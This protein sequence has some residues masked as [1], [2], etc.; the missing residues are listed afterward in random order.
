MDKVPGATGE[1]R[2][3]QFGGGA[4]NLTYE[5]DF[6]EAVY[7]LRRPPLGPV[8]PRSHDMGREH[9]V[10]SR[11]HE[12]FPP[13]PRS[14]HFCSDESIIGAPF[15][16]MERRYGVV[17]RRQ[18]PASYA[19]MPD[20]PEQL[21][22]AL[23][24][25]LAALHAVDY[26]ALGLAGLGKPD[27]FIERQVD[28]WYGRWQRAKSEDVPEMDA[29]HSWLQHNLPERSATSLVHNDYKLDNTM[30]APDDPARLVAVFDWDMATIGDPLSDLGALLT[31]WIEDDDPADARAFSPMPRDASGFPTRAE[32]V[33][34][35]A[36]LSGRDVSTIDFYHVLG[37]YRLA[38]I[39]AQIYI[40]WQRG[41]T[42]DERFAGL[43]ALVRLIA[44]QAVGLAR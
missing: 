34:R 15:V 21:G 37:L 32:L 23:V 9:T 18:L 14:F 27:G 30:F 16:V 13:A 39:L 36:R 40:R 44:A 3:R 12:V 4:A 19:A 28:G 20:A 2:I 22:F 43:G 33:D 24:D 5:L 31:Y 17:V 11:L 25:G 35:Y 8:A 26:Q 10:L 29:V 7:V 38:V 42:R 6:G 1:P 41:Q